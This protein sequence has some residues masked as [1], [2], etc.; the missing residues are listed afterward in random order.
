MTVSTF[1]PLVGAL[2]PVFWAAA[3]PSQAAERPV[4]AKSGMVASAHP[5]ASQTG[6]EILKK[7]G[8]AVDAAVA[9]AFTLGVVEPQASGLGGGGFMLIY[10][11]KTREAEVVDYREVAPRKA[12]PQMYRS[13]RLAELITTGWRSVAVPGTLAG[14]SRA[15]EKYGTRKLP[16]VLLPAAQIAED[17]F[18][19]S[20]L[21]GDLLAIHAAQ[22]S[23]DPEAARIFLKGGK[24]PY[25]TGDTIH[26]KD[27]ARTYRRVAEK[28]AALFYQ[29]EIAE[30]LARAMEAKAEAWMT[31]ED[32]AGYR[33]VEKLP[34]RLNFHGYEFMGPPP[35]A[36][37]IQLFELLNILEGFD[38]GKLNRTAEGFQLIAE[39][40]RR[41]MAD[42]AKFLGDPDF[43]RVPVQGLL[44]KEY[45]ARFR[46]EIKVGR[47]SPRVLPG[48]PQDF[49]R[50]KTTQL[51]VIDREGNIVSL[52]QTINSFFGSGV[53]LPGT[54]ILLNNEMHEF[55]LSA[56]TPNSFAPGKRPVSSMSPSLVLLENRPYLIYGSAG[57]TRIISAMTEVFLNIVESRM[58]LQQAINAPRIHWEQD[59]FMEPRIPDA[60]RLELVRMGY[61]VKVLNP[62]DFYFGGVQGI[63]IDPQT[64]KLYGA[65][66]PRRDG[67]AIGY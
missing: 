4:E 44:S 53:V 14:L 35:T 2:F 67:A 58:N 18:K 59:L 48:N 8:N 21:M 56:G 49:D 5:L 39:G 27:L 11:A 9:A 19:V 1:L 17:G 42:R 29:G 13:P 7:G 38:L 43:V 22:L 6:L 65:A 60:I 25:A 16:E 37:T 66:D 63:L 55:S 61:S 3:V 12:T 32:L 57:A 24:A 28:G 51:C 20:R 62:F 40:Q 33:P 10:R 34:I 23:Q 52:T 46:K 54:G 64:G 31:K 47:M 30:G 45:A 50:G 36:G 15:L 26:L 41:V